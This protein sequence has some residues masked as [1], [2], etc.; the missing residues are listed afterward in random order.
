MLKSGVPNAIKVFDE[1]L[2]PQGI[3]PKG[4][5]ID[6]GDIAYLSKKAR[7]MLDAAGYPDCGIVI[8]NSLDEDII[9][10]LNLQGAKID[11]YGVGERLITA[12]SEPVFGGVYKLVAIDGPK[13]V[14][15]KIKISANVEKITTPGSKT[16][17]R[18]F[19]KESNKAIADLITL[20]DE[21]VDESRPYILFNPVHTW[22]KKKIDNF[23]V[24]ELLVPI[25][26]K[27]KLVYESPSVET[28][29]NYCKEQVDTL[30]DEILRFENPHRYFVDLSYDLWIVKQSLL[31]E[32]SETQL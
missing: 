15:P 26:E 6:S 28:I 25:F 7:E 24:K 19:S 1:V 22:K 4:I 32:Y 2:K 16:V 23:Y 29:R 13:G 10:D 21:K 20:S 27:G 5:R 18:L 8:S 30:W 14:I 3:R 9:L 12:K 31:N 17:Y 11:S